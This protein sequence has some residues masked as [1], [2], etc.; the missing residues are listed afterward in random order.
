M[1]TYVRD[2]ARLRVRTVNSRDQVGNLRAAEIAARDLNGLSLYDALDRVTLIA[3][4]NPE[5][6]DRAAVL[7]VAGV[8]LG[9]A[10]RALPP[11]RTVSRTAE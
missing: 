11:F 8:R 6:L 4:V 7:D 5:K 9:V 3:R 2:V 10:V 1:G